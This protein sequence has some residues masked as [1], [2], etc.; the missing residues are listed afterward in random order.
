MQRHGS[1]SR[2]GESQGQA[3]SEK[4]KCSSPQEPF[5][6]CR[7]VFMVEEK[8]R[9]GKAI[10]INTKQNKHA[11]ASTDAGPTLPSNLVSLRLRVHAFM[12]DPM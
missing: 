5:T 8:G 1:Y 12:D 7:A 2:P 11:H 10:L 4:S 9:G 3:S 6:F